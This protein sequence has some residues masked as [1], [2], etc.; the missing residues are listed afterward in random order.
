MNPRIFSDYNGPYQPDFMLLEYQGTKADLDRLGLSL[1]E[2]MSIT[3]YMDSDEDE[4]LEADGVVHYGVIPGTN[5]KPGWYADT[6]GSVIRY[7]KR[8]K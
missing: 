8:P 2:G 5:G 1:E 4:D 3:V 7:V 6:R